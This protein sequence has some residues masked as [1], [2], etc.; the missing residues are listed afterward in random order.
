MESLGPVGVD[1]CAMTHQH[2]PRVPVP[3]TSLRVERTAYGWRV[4]DPDGGVWWPSDAVQ[5][6]ILAAGDD[7]AQRA[8]CLRLVDEPGAGRW[9]S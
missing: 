8:E 5:Q 7:D 6:R 3:E 1:I 2:D 4:V 9:R